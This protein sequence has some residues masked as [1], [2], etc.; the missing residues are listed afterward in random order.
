MTLV[1][2]GIWID[3]FNAGVPR[4]AELLREGQVVCHRWVLGE[5]LMGS[6]V[7]DRYLEILRELRPAKTLPDEVLLEAID[8]Y[9]WRGLSWV[10]LQLVLSANAGG[11][12]LWTRDE[13]LRRVAEALGVAA[14]R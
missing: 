10:D 1:D 3:H 2:T 5:L 7:P 8:R 9:G 4:L 13:A 14:G 6:G 12:V 11:H